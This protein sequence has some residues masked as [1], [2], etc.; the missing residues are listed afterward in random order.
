MNTIFVSYRRE[1]A[2]GHAGRLF[3]DLSKHF[4]EDSVFM[5]VAGI[6]PGIDFRK[7]ID[8]NIAKCGVL[9]SVIGKTWL[10]SQDEFGKRRIDNPNDFVRLETAA[11]LKRDIPVIPVLVHGARMPRPEDLPDDLSELA[12]RNGVELT[13]ARWDSDVN[14]LIKALARLDTAPPPPPAEPQPVAVAPAPPPSPAPAVA[15]PP[16]VVAPTAT[17]MAAAVQPPASGNAWPKRASLGLGALVVAGAGWFMVQ[18]NDQ[19]KLARERAEQVADQTLMDLNARA[20]EAEALKAQVKQADTARLAA[21]ATAKA[22]HQALADKNVETARKDADRVAAEKKAAGDAPTRQTAVALA[23]DNFV[24]INLLVLF[25]TSS[26]DGA[27]EG[28]AALIKAGQLGDYRVLR[29][30]NSYGEISPNGQEIAFHRCKPPNS[31]IWVSGIDGGN[32]RAIVEFSGNTCKQVR[33]SAD[34]QRI[35]YNDSADGLHIIDIKARRE[36]KMI[37]I[38][39]EG[40]GTHSWSPKGDAIVYSKGKGN[41]RQLYITDLSGKATPLTSAS[42]IAGCAIAQYPAWSPDGRRIAFTACGGKLYTIAA[43]GSGLKDLGVNNAFAPR[44]APYGQWI[45]YLLGVSG[46]ALMRV[47]MDG[48][49]ALK[50]GAMPAEQRGPFSLARVNQ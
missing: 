19:A 45:V 39:G 29:S 24:T 15:T 30:I 34:G 20:L 46:Q 21:E 32:L 47:P 35:S 3:E 37:A 38:A 28:N 10:T 40:L 41:Q 13:H 1:D 5:D 44:W 48:G 14:L 31:G 9:L 27:L 8:R 2:E 16:P 26:T 18:S 33:W 25:Q 11:A 4:G 22:E 6:E 12:F 42:T 23:R 7:A 17:P 50:I 36:I 43:D 49:E